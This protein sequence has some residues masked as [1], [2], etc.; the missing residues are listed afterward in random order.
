MGYTARFNNIVRRAGDTQSTVVDKND[1]VMS[2]TTAPIVG[3]LT[4]SDSLQEQDPHGW[5]GNDW[6]TPGPEI[7]EINADPGDRLQD[8][9]NSHLSEG[10]TPGRIPRPFQARAAG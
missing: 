8:I 3:S 5:E 1:V 2:G 7:W 6:K 9:A 4:K 10:P